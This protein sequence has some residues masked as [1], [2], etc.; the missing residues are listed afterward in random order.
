MSYTKSDGGSCLGDRFFFHSAYFSGDSSRWP[1]VS[2]TW[3][4]SSTRCIYHSALHP[5]PTDGRPGY[6]PFFII[7]S[8]V[9]TGPC[10]DMASTSLGLVPKGVIAG[11]LSAAC[12]FL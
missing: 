7:M 11:S 10:M 6:F 8:K 5:L 12:F 2:G 9:A 3:C 1:I 4:F